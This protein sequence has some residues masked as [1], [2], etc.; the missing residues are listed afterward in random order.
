MAD[1]GGQGILLRRGKLGEE[2]VDRV[3]SEQE[4]EGGRVGGGS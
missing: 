2:S 1:G 3:R 4:K